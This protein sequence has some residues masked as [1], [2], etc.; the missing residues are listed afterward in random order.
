MSADVDGT[1]GRG[2]LPPVRLDAHCER[3]FGLYAEVLGHPQWEL[4]EHDR[5]EG[6]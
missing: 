6:C 3:L 4:C 2:D 5:L 1:S